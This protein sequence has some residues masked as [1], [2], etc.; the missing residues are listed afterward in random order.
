MTKDSIV[1]EK[2]E[3]L[4]LRTAIRAA[5]EAGAGI[6]EVERDGDFNTSF[7]SDDS[8]LTQADRVSHDII[9][10]MLLLTGIPIL[11]EEGKGTSY[12]ERSQ[13]SR[14]WIVDPLDG[15]KEFLKRNGEYTVN[16]ALIENNRPVFGVIFTPATGAL[17]FGGPEFGGWKIEDAYNTLAPDHDFDSMLT[18]ATRMTSS[19]DRFNRPVIVGSRSHMNEET[20]AFIDSIRTKHG[21]VDFVSKGS[22]LKI[23]LVAEGL[24]H[25]YPRM[26]PTMEWDIA[27]GDAISAAV[28]CLLIEHATGNPLQ[29][30]KENLV[31]PNFVLYGNGYR[32]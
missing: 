18:I 4:L 22:S 5:L 15:T 3:T 13:W 11:S 29:Y 28:G 7:K 20:N 2:N 26:A 14:L 10:S 24:A 1:E 16:I 17:Y 27:A 25:I 9:T 8:P 32:P 19:A 30:N 23:C 31:N 6:M 21:D 12:M